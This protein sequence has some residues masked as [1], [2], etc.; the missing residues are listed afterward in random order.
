MFNL[1]KK[2]KS[3]RKQDKSSQSP[4][5]KKFTMDELIKLQKLIK[6]VKQLRK[7]NPKSL[8]LNEEIDKASE[9]SCFYIFDFLYKNKI[10]TDR[11]KAMDIWKYLKEQL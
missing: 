8:N 3:S 7:L 6:D 11:E 5:E 4:L 9:L 2:R 10:Y 1:F